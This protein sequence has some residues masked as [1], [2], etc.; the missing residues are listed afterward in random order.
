[1]VPQIDGDVKDGT[2]TIIWV[3]RHAER[4]D[5]VNKAWRRW[6]HAVTHLS[7]DDPPLSKRGQRTCAILIGMMGMQRSMYILTRERNEGWSA[8]GSYNILLV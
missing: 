4:E 7:K 2:S 5:N 8:K 1:M 3:V 6:F